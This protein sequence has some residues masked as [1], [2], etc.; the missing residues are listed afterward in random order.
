[1]T[2]HDTPTHLEKAIAPYV[3]H[4]EA[5]PALQEL[6]RAL[7]ELRSGPHLLTLSA[8]RCAVAPII[9]DLERQISEEQ[10]AHAA[11]ILKL[12]KCG[13]PS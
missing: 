1:M 13:D 10:E 2:D 11:T 8:V 5:T 9:A 12:A 3:T 4:R 7:S 6:D